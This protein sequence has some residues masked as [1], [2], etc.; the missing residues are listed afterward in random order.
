MV[1]IHQWFLK[2]L[3]TI[4]LDAKRTSMALISRTL[5][6]KLVA[7]DGADVPKSCQSLM[8]SIHAIA[9]FSALEDYLKPRIAGILSFRPS[10][11]TPHMLQALAG[12]GLS[13]SALAQ[14]MLSRLGTRPGSSSGSSGAGAA[15]A[16]GSFLSALTGSSESGPST[17]TT[18]TTAVHSGSLPIPI[19][20]RRGTGESG[21]STSTVEPSA[22][23]IGSATSDAPSLSRRRSL[24]LR[25]QPPAEASTSTSATAETTAPTTSATSAPIPMSSSESRAALA[26]SLLQQLLVDDGDLDDDLE[27]EASLSQA[28]LTYSDTFQVGE[29]G[30]EI[31]G[32]RAFNLAFDAGKLSVRFK[33]VDAHICI[34]NGGLMASTPQGTRIATPLNGTTP[35]I[36]APIAAL[37][38]ANAASASGGASSKMSYA[39]VA[40]SAIEKATDF[41]L[42][43]RLKEDVLPMDMTV[44]G[45]CHQHEARRSTDGQLYP[46]A[47]WNGNYTITYRKIPGKRPARGKTHHNLI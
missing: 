42:E 7:E 12:S 10:D 22:P 27:N 33:P 43:F 40:A 26:S 21:S 1:R 5:R 36:D 32:D 37:A 46:H 45:A 2:G 41:Y 23:A 25:G 44:Y 9:P 39:G 35:S 30:E 15:S 29:E 47:V 17:P 20:V 24:R 16:L 4:T 38:A 18:T 34:A 14:T 6:L 3:L 8:V 11:L 28:I 13:S 19:P 31:I